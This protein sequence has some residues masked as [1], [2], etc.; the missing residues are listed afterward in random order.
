MTQAVYQIPLP[1][2]SVDSV[3][4]ALQRVFYNLQTSDF[5]VGE[6]QAL[7]GLRRWRK[8]TL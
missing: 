7:A 5:S 4:L 3:P 8:L 6:C 2:D 1:E